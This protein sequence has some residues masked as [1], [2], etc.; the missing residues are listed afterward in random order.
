M[1]EEVIV[2]VGEAEM[3]EAEEATRWVKQGEEALATHLPPMPPSGEIA[4]LQPRQHHPKTTHIPCALLCHLHPAIVA[5]GEF[6]LR[7]ASD[8]HRGLLLGRLL[9]LTRALVLAVDALPGHRHGCKQQAS[10]RRRA[11]RAVASALG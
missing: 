6:E 3:G 5:T 8:G 9:L 7:E 4:A 2:T 10:A 11:A 1:E